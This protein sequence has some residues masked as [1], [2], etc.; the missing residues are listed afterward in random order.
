MRL[1]TNIK[2][3]RMTTK[4]LK[5]IKQIS[6]CFI[7]LLIGLTVR[8]QDDGYLANRIKPG[9][10]MYLDGQGNECFVDYRQWDQ[11]APLGTP[12]GVV[13]YSYYGVEPYALTDQPGWHGWVVAMDESDAVAWAPQN[14]P[15]YNNCVAYYEVEGI[16]TPY[17]PNRNQKD[18]A[19]A[20]TCGWQNTYRFLE[21]LY[22]GQQ[23]TLSESTSPAFYYLFASKNG[24]T[25]F[26][27]KPS[28]HRTSWFMPSYGQ[29][30]ML[31]SQLGSVNL[32]LKVAG[33][34]MLNPARSWYSSTEIGT[35]KIQ[36]AWSVNSYGYSNT[37]PNWVKDQQRNVRAVRIF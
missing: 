35:E 19:Y 23:R 29:V 7:L 4:K 10:L 6:I 20:D 3:F 22:T 37:E 2:I 28:M 18:L 11:N 30:R 8:A 21:F 13:F 5:R 14:S 32:A 31:Y 9:D 15:C 12:I 25:D 36:A 27:V 1:I 26:S 24:V 33:G 34:T 16:N 17:N